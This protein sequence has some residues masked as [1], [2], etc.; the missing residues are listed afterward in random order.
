MSFKE[1]N[2]RLKLIEFHANWNL[3][4]TSKT[5]APLK[6]SI[7]EYLQNNASIEA[8]FFNSYICM[9]GIK[10]IGYK[11]I[12]EAKESN[13]TAYRLINEIE[14]EPIR[15]GYKSIY[16]AMRCWL[17]L[18]NEKESFKELEEL[19]ELDKKHQASGTQTMFQAS[20]HATKGFAFSRLSFA[21]YYESEIE[22]KLA[23]DACPDNVEWLFMFGLIKWRKGKSG[24]GRY[25]T[26]SNLDN[27]EII[28]NKVLEYKSDHAYAMAISADIKRRKYE[29]KNKEFQDCKDAS[30]LQPERNQEYYVSKEHE[31]Y[32]T[33]LNDISN[34][35]SILVSSMHNALRPKILSI[36]AQ[37]FIRMG[38]AYSVK[39]KSSSTDIQQTVPMPKELRVLCSSQLQSGYFLAARNVIDYAKS[40][41]KT[42]ACIISQEAVLRREQNN[43]EQELRCL[44]LAIKLNPA[45][46]AAKIEKTV[47]LTRIG[48]QEE[49][50]E[51]YDTLPLNFKDYPFA[52]FDINYA[53]AM[54]LNAERKYDEALSKNKKCLEIAFESFVKE[55]TSECVEFYEEQNR[56]I[57]SVIKY[58]KRNW[59]IKRK[60]DPYDINP[61]LNLAELNEKLQKYRNA[62]FYYQ[63][64]LGTLL[65]S[66]EQHN[67]HQELNIRI[68]LANVTLKSGNV[69]VASTMLAFL[70]GM[71]VREDEADERLKIL[72]MKAYVA[73]AEGEKAAKSGDQEGA[74]K[75]FI[76]ATK[77]GNLQGANKLLALIGENKYDKHFFLYCALIKQCVAANTGKDKSM[78]ENDLRELVLSYDGDC[79]MKNTLNELRQCQLEMEYNY[80]LSRLYSCMKIS[81]VINKA[82][83]ILNYAVTMFRD[84]NYPEA[85]EKEEW[86]DNCD[87]FIIYDSTAD[88]VE[89]KIV[90]K[91]KKR[92]WTDFRN[93]FTN[94]LDFLVA[95]QPV[96]DPVNNNWLMALITL[97]NIQKHQHSL[98]LY[99]NRDGEL[100]RENVKIIEIARC[101]C[102]HLRTIVEEFCKYYTPS[103]SHSGAN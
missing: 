56:G 93:K 83:S 101:A 82:R 2:D 4:N 91:L 62:C 88:E 96:T 63:E 10:G 9:S 35:I 37:S 42:A 27:V 66:N 6:E 53:F 20:I 78:L 72:D 16:L 87:F 7:D 81:I 68:G 32:K 67:R 41:F 79:L 39:D 34:I 98:S 55:G 69:S 54:Y 99:K 50:L 86:K 21:R 38:S 14:N 36:V 47:A 48:R 52:Y 58:L 76:K 100:V 60:T 103:G 40:R 59:E 85:K 49:A 13:E 97:D 24:L 23:T 29:H 30:D 94:L 46:I 22:L 25:F 28:M 71:D 19:K 5:F 45:N 18:K 75:H 15:D 102:F 33:K 95:I 64:A 73:V 84:K 12:L 17:A 77:T 43:T 70:D 44:E 90:K 8:H 89:N 1:I 92:G 11:D 3:E 80:L 65:Q 26:S 61:K 57:W 51:I 74:L 31:L